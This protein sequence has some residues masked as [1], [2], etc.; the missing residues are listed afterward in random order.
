MVATP[1]HAK[2]EPAPTIVSAARGRA[3]NARR[4]IRAAALA[5]PS[6]TST[7]VIVQC[8]EVWLVRARRRD[9]RD[10]DHADDDRR[11]REV[12]V[13]PGVLAEHPLRR[14]TSSTSS[15][16]ASAG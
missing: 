13:A 7:S 6:T 1:L 5:A 10:A 9:Q 8:S 2:R 15:P 11:H 12:L 3:P 16:I 14:A 4:T